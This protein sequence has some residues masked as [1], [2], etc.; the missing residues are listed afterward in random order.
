MLMSKHVNF[1]WEQPIN[2]KGEK[3]LEMKW[4]K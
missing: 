3:K 1:T 2:R 4:T